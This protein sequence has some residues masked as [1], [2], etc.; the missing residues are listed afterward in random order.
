MRGTG[1]WI[2]RRERTRPTGRRKKDV[3]G[4][5]EK[6]TGRGMDQDGRKEGKLERKR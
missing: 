2:E 1:G 3:A 4:I 6:G 5:C